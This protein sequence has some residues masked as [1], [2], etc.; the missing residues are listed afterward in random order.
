MTV[1]TSC[2]QIFYNSGAVK[3]QRLG[4][5]ILIAQAAAHRAPDWLVVPK[6]F[7]QSV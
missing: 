7:Q 6:Q 3:E 2:V 5:K 4:P 1:D